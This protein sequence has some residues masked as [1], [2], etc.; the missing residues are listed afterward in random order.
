MPSQLQITMTY[1]G[2]VAEVLTL[3]NAPDIFDRV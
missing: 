3:D 2:P 1:R